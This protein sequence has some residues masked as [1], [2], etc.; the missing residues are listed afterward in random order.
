MYVRDESTEESQQSSFLPL[1]NSP[2]AVSVVLVIVVIVNAFLLL[3]HNSTRVTRSD[4]A[5]P[6]QRGAGKA[7]DS[8]IG[9]IACVGVTASPGQD[10]SA[11]AA[12]RPPGTTFCVRD[13]TY[14]VTKPIRL[15]SGDSFV[16]LYSDGSRP[17]IS[18]ERAREIFDGLYYR[19]GQ[20]EGSP[21]YVADGARIEGLRVTGA[22]GGE[23]CSPD[24]GRGIGGGKNLTVVDVRSDHNTNQG[25]GGSLDGL[26]I[27]GSVLD[28]NGSEP[29]LDFDGHG[30][31]AGVKSVKSMTIRDTRVYA[32]EWTGIW[33]DLGCAPF[34]VEN[35]RSNRNGKAGIQYEVSV[36]PATISGSTFKGN[37]WRENATRHTGIVIAATQNVE[38]YNNTFGGNVNYA[39]EIIDSPKRGVLANVAVHDNVLN[40]DTI[41]GCG[42]VESATCD[43]N[44]P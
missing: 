13:G 20:P 15:Q 38:V 40:G 24:C 17:T 10:L 7:G 2:I 6:A 1:L 35:V 16:G 39:V 43:R 22:V 11:L 34:K 33:C 30:S 12:S 27:E 4:S 37:G 3:W 5:S 26:L 21:P 42:V 14:S 8:G 32:N 31:A 9:A 36:G 19:A 41:K 28:H 25:I 29:F 44:S 23:R 18:T